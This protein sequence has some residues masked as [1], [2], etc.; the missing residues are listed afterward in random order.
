MQQVLKSAAVWLMH[1]EDSRKRSHQVATTK[2]H[3]KR[4]RLEPEIARKILQILDNFTAQEDQLQSKP[5]AAV[6]VMCDPP[7][8]AQPDCTTQQ[9]QS[10][11]STR[12]ELV[13]KELQQSREEGLHKRETSLVHQ[14]F[15]AQMQAAEGARQKAKTKQQ[16]QRKAANRARQIAENDRAKFGRS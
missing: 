1:G 7:P 6:P 10:A 9:R 2:C 16:A 5:V 4:R 12:D 14:R 13:R 11:R 8:A 3:G 15:R